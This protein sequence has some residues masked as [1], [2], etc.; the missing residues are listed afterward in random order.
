[1]KNIITIFLMLL[2]LAAYSQTANL[3][4]AVRYQISNPG[5]TGTFPTFT[6]A[7]TVG[8][9]MSR[10]NATNIQVGDS[11]YVLN[12]G[13]DL[14]ICRVAVINSAVGNALNITVTC[15]TA[16]V[17]SLD[18]GQAA[19]IRPTSINKLP[20]YIS[21][22][23][24][25]LQ[26][27]I[28]NR[29]SQII[30]NI[31]IDI[32]NFIGIAGVSPAVSAAANSGETWRNTAGEL[33]ESNGV[34][35]Q[36]PNAVA[37]DTLNITQTAHGF[38]LGQVV[39]ISSSGVARLA[40]IDVDSLSAT[41]VV[42]RVIS[43]N[44]FAV[45]F[46]GTFSL[47]GVK[48][49][50]NYY[51]SSFP[52]RVTEVPTERY[53]LVF[54]GLV[55]GLA[56]LT[57]DN[58]HVNQ[59]KNS[60]GYFN[61]ILGT[62]ASSLIAYYPLDDV[63][64][65]SAREVKNG[66]NALY[67]NSPLLGQTGIGDGI[68][69]VKFN[70]SNNYISAD[71]PSLKTAW[72]GD[73]GAISFWINLDSATLNSASE[74]FIIVFSTGVNSLIVKKQAGVASVS[75]EMVSG[76]K[77]VSAIQPITTGWVHLCVVWSKRNQY[78]KLY[79]N[80]SSDSPTTVPLLTG[81]WSGTLSSSTMLF[82]NNSSAG[83]SS[84]G[85]NL[86]HVSI[87]NDYLSDG[88]VNRLSGLG[89]F[90]F[91]QNKS[92]K[93]V[94]QKVLYSRYS[95]N[96][97]LAFPSL[98]KVNNGLWLMEYVSNIQHGAN[99]GQDSVHIRFSNNQG[100]TWSKRDTL[101]DG[102]TPVNG[103]PLINF[104]TTTARGSKIV[105]VNNGDL[106]NFSRPNTTTPAEQNITQYRS[107]DQGATWVSE[108]TVLSYNLVPDEY[109]I[110]TGVP[111]SGIY[112]IMRDLS[113]SG[114]EN[115]LLYRSQNFGVSWA[116]RGTIDAS[117]LDANESGIEHVGGGK[118]IVIQRP[119]TGSSQYTYRYTSNDYGATWSAPVV[120]PILNTVHKPVLN[121]I[122]GV[123][124]MHG[125]DHKSSTEFYTSV[126][127][128]PDLGETWSEAYHVDSIGGTL[129]GGYTG[130]LKKTDGNLYMISYG[131]TL[132]TA[133]IKEYIIQNS[134]F[135][136]QIEI[137]PSV[138]NLID[139]YIPKALGPNNFENSRIYEDLTNIGINTNT[140]EAFLHLR[141]G[142]IAGVS[143]AGIGQIT[144]EALGSN[145]QYGTLMSNNMA[146]GLIMRDAFQ[147]LGGLRYNGTT[148]PSFPNR[149]EFFTDGIVTPKWTID[150]LGNLGGGIRSPERKLHLFITDVVQAPQSDVVFLM[151]KG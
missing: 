151:E 72:N 71:N 51:T 100:V 88:D 17:T 104:G 142:D 109:C 127:K 101:L 90:D 112:V 143:A 61:T 145:V 148:F 53:Q 124:Y 114:N 55:N 47:E 43:A 8:D 52:G 66:W 132:N 48:S 92:F 10:W 140:P 118:M 49:G 19:I 27:L 13:Q 102:T 16:G 146:S 29:Q 137:T 41:G 111:D 34:V 81:T 74:K 2:S 73:N 105:R 136:Y 46:S 108:G 150:S 83:T 128:S 60:Y 33:W 96:D 65:T 21:G 138:T 79:K 149:L 68:T 58:V 95:G 32:T 12:G 75:A 59:Q 139:N 77:T 56:M 121:L 110:V 141:V 76:G 7:G 30:D 57:I 115:T 1:M 38:L 3:N 64:G 37:L 11:L 123:L 23:Q 15:V 22:L 9:D 20:T 126:W 35:W 25:P 6:V 117:V 26:S 44:Q 63:S 107:T 119:S 14:A 5:S 87:W 54:R 28:L 89:R 45:Q 91:K 129:D 42:I 69:S 125:R 82:G 147:S 134:N 86:A 78:F 116:L 103:F 94:T 84:L 120:I 70:A 122:D 24:S 99:S 50:V 85:G 113:I 80:G 135:K 62:K 97:H 130:L 39:N 133:A 18:P 4:L 98:V 36:R 67:G 31:N 144:I 40:D 131:G 93:T 106:L